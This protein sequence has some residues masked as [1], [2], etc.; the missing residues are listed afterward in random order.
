MGI[1]RGDLFGECRHAGL[2]ANVQLQRL[3]AGIGCRDFVQCLPP[4]TR[5]DH[6]VAELVEGFSEA[7]ADPRSAAR[8]QNGIVR[9]L[10]RVSPG[11]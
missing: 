3:H 6:L 5:D 11:W 1:T 8:D 10:H 9:D 2:V 7:A 4:P